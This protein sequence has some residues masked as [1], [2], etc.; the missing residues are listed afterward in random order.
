MNSLPTNHNRCA[1]DAQLTGRRHQCGERLCSFGQHCGVNQRGAVACMGHEVALG[2]PYISEGIVT[3]SATLFGR[4][5]SCTGWTAHTTCGS[6][7]C[8][9]WAQFAWGKKAWVD[10]ATNRVDRL[11]SS[12][13]SS[14]PRADDMLELE[15][16]AK[17]LPERERRLIGELWLNAASGEHASIAS[18][19]AH[20]LELLAVGVPAHLLAAVHEAAQDEIRHARMS[21]TVASI[22]LDSEV[23]PAALG[24]SSARPNPTTLLAVLI[25]TARDG[26]VSETVAA[27]EALFSLRNAVQTNAPRLLQDVLRSIAEDEMRHAALAWRTVAWGLSVEPLAGRPV[28]AAIESHLSDVW[29]SRAEM[30]QGEL[31]KGVADDVVYKVRLDEFLGGHGV[32][33]ATSRFQACKLAAEQLI[34]P[35]LTALGPG[36]EA[37]NSPRSHEGGLLIERVEAIL[38]SASV[39]E[40]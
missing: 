7:S 24:I 26:C 2:R 22:Y 31:N 6:K 36:N 19:A 38:A 37:N 11:E 15:V 5:A 12:Q 35:A 32:L 20:S 9:A 4:N 33:G 27:F 40:L 3:T 23:G 10:K 18:F 34:R 14:P 16:M 13:Q 29:A 8:K 28:M 21:Y 30:S 39:V 25:S 1:I 17:A